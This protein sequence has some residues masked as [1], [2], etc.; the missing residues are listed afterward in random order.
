LFAST[1]YEKLCS[2]ITVCILVTFGCVINTVALVMFPPCRPIPYPTPSMYN[3]RLNCSV[4]SSISSAAIGILAMAVEDPL[5]KVAMYRPGVKSASAKQR[6]QVKCKILISV[7][8]EKI[9]V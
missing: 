9:R 5:V 1:V 8:C 2:K 7:H 4:G 6:G 3:I